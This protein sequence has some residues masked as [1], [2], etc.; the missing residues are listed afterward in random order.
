MDG[1]VRSAPLYGFPLAKSSRSASTCASPGRISAPAGNLTTA[2]SWQ[3]FPDH[4]VRSQ[5]SASALKLRL[6]DKMQESCSPQRYVRGLLKCHLE[7]IG[8]LC[9]ITFL[10]PPLDGVSRDVCHCCSKC[11]CR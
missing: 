2:R 5:A 8:R 1:A 3:T 4:A 11:S 10:R 7:N 9:W 6:R